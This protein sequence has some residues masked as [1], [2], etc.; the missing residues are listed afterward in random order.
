MGQSVY[1]VTESTGQLKKG[2]QIYLDGKH[3][4]HFEVYDKNGKAKAVLN[5][6]GSI[7]EKKTAAGSSR[8][9]RYD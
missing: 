6:D 5:V 4:N 7:N 8:G 3:K 9:E 1:R 2:D